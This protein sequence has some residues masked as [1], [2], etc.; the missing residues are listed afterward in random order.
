MIDPLFDQTFEFKTKKIAVQMLF[1]AGCHFNMN[2]LTIEKLQDELGRQLIRGLV[3]VLTIETDEAKYPADWWQA[4]KDRWF[5]A[6]LKQRYP[7]RM[8]QI[9]ADHIFAELEPPEQVLGRET[10]RLRIVDADDLKR[11]LDG[12]EQPRDH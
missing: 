2:R 6:W 7:V 11:R 9:I 12:A 3:S 4:L 8:K 10:I 5:P 1:D